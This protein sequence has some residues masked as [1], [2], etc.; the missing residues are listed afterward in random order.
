MCVHDLTYP[1]SEKMWHKIS[2]G[3][4]KSS[5]VVLDYGHFCK[6]SLYF[7]KFHVLS[8]SLWTCWGLEMNICLQPPKWEIGS[9]VLLSQQSQ[10]SSAHGKLFKCVV[11]RSPHTRGPEAGMCDCHASFSFQGLTPFSFLH[12]T[13]LRGYFARPTKASKVQQTQAMVPQ[14][15]TNSTKAAN[16]TISFSTA[17]RGNTRGMQPCQ[18]FVDSC[19]LYD[20]SSVCND[21]MLQDSLIVTPWISSGASDCS[22][23]D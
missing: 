12:S 17:K 4:E 15:Q 10:V 20:C 19:L 11:F 1:S 22:D 14:S 21:L 5:C 2:P 8:S 9:A 16:H 13:D 3:F 18:T 7:P 23:I 6:I